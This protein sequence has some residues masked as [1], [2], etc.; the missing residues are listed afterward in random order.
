MDQPTEPPPP[1]NLD[2]DP[3]DFDTLFAN[4]LIEMMFETMRLRSNDAPEQQ[5]ARRKAA[6]TALAAMKQTDPVGMMFAAH[7][8]ATHHATMECFRRAMLAVNDPD[9]ATRLHKNA[10][11]LSRMMAETVTG[12]ARRQDQIPGGKTP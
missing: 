3:D 2:E 5:A 7:A 10:M 11:G 6:I 9:A 8:I 12:L 1:S 4:D